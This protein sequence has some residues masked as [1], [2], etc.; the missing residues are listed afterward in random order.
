MTCI[1]LKTRCVYTLFITLAGFTP[2][3]F[4]LMPYKV[5]Q[6]VSIL[7]YV[8]RLTILPFYLRLVGYGQYADWTNI[9][10]KEPLKGTADI[11]LTKIKIH[12]YNTQTAYHTSY[13][14]NTFI[15]YT[16]NHIM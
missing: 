6:A 7:V 1:P 5:W 15:N 2:V 16:H 9:G 3:V 11:H 8:Y 10:F 4:D 12:A 13:P 14:S